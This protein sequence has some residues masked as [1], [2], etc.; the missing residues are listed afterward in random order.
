MFGLFNFGFDVSD[1][2]GG[3]AYILHG[4]EGTVL[5]ILFF[6]AD[7]VVEL[8]HVVPPEIF[9]VSVFELF[10]E[11]MFTELF[12]DEVTAFRVGDVFVV[13]LLN[14]AAILFQKSAYAVFFAADPIITGVLDSESS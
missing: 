4:S 11:K 9:T 1:D 13:W 5:D 2:G 7:V 10:P 6:D 3:N 8:S 14:V 12:E